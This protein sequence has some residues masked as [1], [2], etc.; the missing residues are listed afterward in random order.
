[1]G[2]IKRG[3]KNAFRNSIR[4]FSIILILALS[5]GLALTML[6]S[7]QAVQGKI[8]SVKSS[9]GN[10]I[11]VSPAGARGFEGGGEPLTTTEVNAIKNTSH[12]TSVT[13]SI[14]A[15]MTSDDTNLVSSIDPGTLGRRGF[16]F[17]F[18]D[19]NGN[20]TPPA[21]F[22]LPVSA[23]GT[24]DPSSLQAAGGGKT[25]LTSG[26][27]IN[28][29]SSDDIALVGTSLATKNNL[30]VGSTFTAFGQ[31][32]TVSGIFDSGNQFSNASVVFPL[33][34]LQ[35]LSGQ[36]DQVDSILVQADSIT[37]VQAV[38]DS[39]K[40]TLGSKADVV[41]QQDSSSMA[42]TPL[43][44]IKN[45]SLYSLI[46]SLAA[47]AVIVLLIM[48]MIVRER[49]R[50]IGVLKAIGASDFRI[51][52]QFMTESLVFTIL[53]AAIGTVLGAVFSNS[54]TQ[55]LV[56]NASSAIQSAAPNGSG[57]TRTGGGIGRGLQ[58][59]SNGANPRSLLNLKSSVD[60][61]ILLYGLG[62][63]ILI[64]ILGSAIPAYLT[65]K[66]RPAEVLRSE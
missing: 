13:P 25:T 45:I 28:G 11:T 59:I 61:H 12:V 33:A 15:R 36:A 63:A 60:Y 40:N 50:E 51:V 48:V 65:A 27:M 31:T 26:S 66:V 23:L 21:N 39:L 14:N 20:S 47:G 53:G 30:K 64:A 8:D 56:S 9:I 1:M 57:F 4:T 41:S 3:I 19:R 55:L 38:S 37:D 16:G 24:T 18:R 5:V 52:G 6:L 17:A 2:T 29:V 22:T 34:T 46:G 7:L 44:S 32:I 42:L 10:F 43:E 49:R 58:I 35:S 54:V 62:A